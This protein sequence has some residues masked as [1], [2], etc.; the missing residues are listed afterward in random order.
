MSSPRG[1]AEASQSSQDV[2]FWDNE[3]VDNNK[4][5]QQRGLSVEEMIKQ[6]QCYEDREEEEV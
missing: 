6:H 5:Q 3:E 2:G 4:E 1:E